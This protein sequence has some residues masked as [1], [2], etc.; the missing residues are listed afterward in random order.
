MCCETNSHY[1]PLLPVLLF[2]SPH[3]SIFDTELPYECPRCIRSYSTKAKL[4]RHLER[5]HSTTPINNPQIQINSTETVTTT[6]TTTTAPVLNNNNVDAPLPVMTNNNNNNNNE[7]ASSG[8]V[9]EEVNI[10]NPN[11]NNHNNSTIN[12]NNNNNNNG[13]IRD[14]PSIVNNDSKT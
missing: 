5:N 13:L 12:N 9:Y 10:I 1:I 14:M 2:V 7:N 11:P 3:S 6:T 4:L 8:K